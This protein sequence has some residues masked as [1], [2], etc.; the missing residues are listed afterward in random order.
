MRRA[1]DLEVLRCRRCAGRMQLIA[2]I[3]GAA[4]IQRILANLGLP[5]TRDDPPPPWFMTAAGAEQP[6]LPGVTV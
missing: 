2:T 5:D 4:V 1:F 6:T 3:E